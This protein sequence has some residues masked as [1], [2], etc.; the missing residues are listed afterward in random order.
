MQPLFDTKQNDNNLNMIEYRNQRTSDPVNAHLTPGPSTYFNPFIHVYNP[1][2]EADNPLVTNI[3][4][5]R[6]PLS[7]CPFVASLKQISLKSDFFPFLC[8]CVFL[9]CFC[10]FLLFFFCFLFF[11]SHVY[12]PRQGQTTHWGQKIYDNRKAF[13]L[14]PNVASF[15]MISSKSDF[16]LIFNDLKDVYSPGARV[17]NPWDKLFMSI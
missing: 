6:K 12:S 5:N 8:V 15:K 17:E 10:F 16:I 2:A 3:N 4:V 13:S 11:F 7:I 14:C 1:R 9:F